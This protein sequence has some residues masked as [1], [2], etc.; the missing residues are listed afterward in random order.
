MAAALPTGWLGWGKP[1]LH[2]YL[3]KFHGFLLPLQ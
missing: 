3:Q 2:A 1:P